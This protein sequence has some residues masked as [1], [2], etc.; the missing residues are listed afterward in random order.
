MDS[1]LFDLQKYREYKG[2]PPLPVDA[3]QEVADV[4]G[5]TLDPEDVD[6]TEVEDSD[7]ENPPTPGRHQRESSSSCRVSSP[8][9]AAAKSGESPA[10][11]A[12]T[13]RGSAILID[14][15]EESGLSAGPKRSRSS[16]DDTKAAEAQKKNKHTKA[17]H[18]PSRAIPQQPLQIT[19]VS[20]A[21]PKDS[22]G[23]VAPGASPP[24][25]L[26]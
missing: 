10:A 15:D 8:P 23:G 5:A 17:A 4:E 18:D 14:D 19:P 3:P 2:L 20:S 26:K 6:E 1:F 24:P 25:V 21:P 12:G 9:P 11:I 7:E 13:A 16:G 22:V